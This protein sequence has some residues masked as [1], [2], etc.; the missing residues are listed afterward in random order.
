MSDARPAETT[1]PPPAP[2][3][4]GQGKTAWVGLFLIL[5]ILG[6]L[7]VLFVMTDAAVFRGRYMVRTFVSDAGGIR[8]GDPV[9]MRGV[10]IGRV[11]R[12]MIQPNGTVG[13][14]LEIEGEY[15]IPTDSQVKLSSA[16]PLGGMKA[17]VIPGIAPT[18]A[19]YGDT[20]GG[21]TE[22]GLEEMTAQAGDVLARVQKL[23]ADQT[24]ANVSGSTAELQ[25]LLKQM[26]GA[27]TEQ[28][29]ELVVLMAS[30]QRSSSSLEKAVAA[31][32]LERSIKRLDGI[33]AKMDDV[34]QTLDRGTRSMESVAGR[35]DK[36]EGSLGK[37]TKDDALYDD[38]SKA[39]LNISQAT[40]NITK[41]TEEIRRN[42]KKYLKVSVF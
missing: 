9:R 29:K 2:P 3:V 32:E 36:G 22:K 15:K 20:L 37:L 33:S 28:R 14:D 6:G 10:N 11:K 34:T 40:E 17:D 42:P 4:R 18:N 12:F 1:P 30:L 23:L 31:P 19:K 25:T 21:Q 38:M 41:L 35:I 7:T 24:I 5:G 39:A 16:G 13:I 27:V 8:G 26:N